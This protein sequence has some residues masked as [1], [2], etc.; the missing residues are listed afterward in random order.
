[1]S[2]PSLL[3]VEEKPLVRD[4]NAEVEAACRRIPPLWPL[5][6]FVAVNPFV[7]LSDT[8]FPTAVDLISRVG[9]AP[10]LVEPEAVKALDGF[11]G[12]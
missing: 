10:I 7:G 8:P 1:M 4:T 5:Q 9:H 6:S 2:V 11:L 3:T 12:G